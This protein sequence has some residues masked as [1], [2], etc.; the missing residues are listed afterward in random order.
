MPF[1]I[2]TAFLLLRGGHIVVMWFLVL[3]FGEEGAEVGGVLGQARSPHLV[4]RPSTPC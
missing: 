4:W 1:C 2:D 3:S